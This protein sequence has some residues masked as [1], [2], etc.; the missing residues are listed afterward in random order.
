MTTTNYYA[1]D[2]AWQPLRKSQKADEDPDKIAIIFASHNRIFYNKDSLEQQIKQHS[3][4][5]TDLGLQVYIPDD[6]A[7]IHEW[8]EEKGAPRRRAQHIIDALNDLSVKAI[9]SVGGSGADEVIF[10]LEK[11]YSNPENL[12]KRED[13]IP[14][15]GYSDTT[16]LQLYLGSIGLVSPIQVR[17]DDP[18]DA[19]N[20]KEALESLFFSQLLQQEIPLT[21][22]NDA[23]KDEKDE[24]AAIPGTIIGGHANTIYRTRRCNYRIDANADEDG[25]KIL[26]LE[27][28]EN[29]K[30]Y[31][32]R[33]LETL[34]DTGALNNIK[35]II[36]G[37]NSP[38]VS[39]YFKNFEIPVLFGVPIGHGDDSEGFLPIPLCTKT[40]INLGSNPSISISPV[41]TKENIKKSKEE[42]S[43]REPW[44]PKETITEFEQKDIFSTINLNPITELSEDIAAP[45]DV[46]ICN[47]KGTDVPA[48]EGVDLSDKNLLIHMTIPEKSQGGM[49]DEGLAQKIRGPLMELLKMGHASNA[50]SIIFSAP[51][52]FT[53]RMY[54]NL[55]NFTEEYFP[56]VKDVFTALIS[57]DIQIIKDLGEEDI[58]KPLSVRLHDVRIETEIDQELNS[59][60]KLQH[61]RYK[62]KLMS[63]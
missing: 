52:K 40:T 8:G 12:P 62:L 46:I 6:L 28:K 7:E 16:Q 41:R 45:E 31:I 60:S 19:K 61:Q 57:E 30:D 4:W 32:E 43:A 13:A 3:A 17:C 10:E 38:D 47:V 25:S 42:Y 37:K 18:G 15:I 36:I 50:K 1:E 20:V 33:A 39:E 24:K 48:L 55:K 26:L 22:L 23:A 63:F 35:A 44:Q 14:L 27:G 5:I 29:E 58:S 21:P 53:P 34:K 59:D 51:I 2:S 54:N 11:Y 9:F 56:E 49:E